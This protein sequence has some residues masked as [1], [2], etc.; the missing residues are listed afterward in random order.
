MLNKIKLI[1]SLATIATIAGFCYFGKVS[2]DK[3]MS[4]RDRMHDAETNVV[5]YQNIINKKIKDNYAL[6]LNID[7]LSY[8]NDKLIHELDSVR[9]SLKLDLNKPGAIMS[10]ITSVIHDTTVID[11][12]DQMKNCDSVSI[13]TTIIRNKDTKYRI[14]LNKKELF[15]DLDIN[16]TQYLY[17]YT[18][19]GYA[20]NY[21]N[22]FDR[23][24]HLDYTKKDMTKY[25]IKNSNELITIQ[26]TRIIQTN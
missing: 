13:D 18:C 14:K 3:Y 1:L 8:S 10:G 16:N 19:R 17:V 22:W 21:K 7:D 5:A 6:R 12:S 15:C 9:K 23:L 2:Y 20:Q 26:D 24:I 25:T 11:L 4:M